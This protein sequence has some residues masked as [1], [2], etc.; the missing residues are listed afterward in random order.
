MNGLLKIFLVVAEV[1]GDVEDLT[2]DL[3]SHARSQHEAEGQHRHDRGGP[4]E[5]NAFQ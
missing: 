1:A 5:M 3:P 2:S 4:A